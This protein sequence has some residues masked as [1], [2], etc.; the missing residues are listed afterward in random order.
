MIA[1]NLEQIQ[2]QAIPDFKFAGATIGDVVFGEPD[3]KI[4]RQINK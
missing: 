4:E 2:R 1:Q 3:K